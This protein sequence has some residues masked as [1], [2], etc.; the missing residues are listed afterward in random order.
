[1]KGKPE[2]KWQPEVGR[3][4]REAVAA[5][6]TSG[7]V[8]LLVILLVWF[9]ILYMLRP[10]NNLYLKQRSNRSEIRYSEKCM[11]DINL[12]LAHSGNPCCARLH[13][14]WRGLHGTVA[15][16]PTTV[17]YLVSLALIWSV[18]GTAEKRTVQRSYVQVVVKISWLPLLMR[19]CCEFDIEDH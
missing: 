11:S 1:M 9:L 10:I 5:M 2:Y 13:Y 6:Q 14:W 7:R 15:P 12:S 8:S 17:E 18:S 16:Y 3:A 4:C 19:F